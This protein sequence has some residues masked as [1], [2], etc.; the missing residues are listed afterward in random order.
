MIDKIVITRSERASP[1]CFVLTYKAE[2]SIKTFLGLNS[3]NLVLFKAK[4]VDIQYCFEKYTTQWQN[5]PSM[6]RTIFYSV[7]LTFKNLNVCVRSQ[8]TDNSLKDSKTSLNC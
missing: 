8:L 3:R 1:F 6:D 7:Q 5:L 4:V 2:G